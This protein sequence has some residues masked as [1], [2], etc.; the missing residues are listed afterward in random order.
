MKTALQFVIRLYKRVLSPI[1]PP[2]CRFY[3]SCSDYAHEALERHGLVKGVYLSLYRI[4]RC[5]PF[6]PGGHDPVP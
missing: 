5:H 2:S 3:P 6:N 1:L 4:L